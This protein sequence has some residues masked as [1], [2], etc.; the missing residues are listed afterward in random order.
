MVNRKLENDYFNW[1]YFIMNNDIPD[2]IASFRKLFRH[3]HRVEFTYIIPKD[4]NRARDGLDLRY[5]Y[6]LENHIKDAEDRILGPCSV[7]EMM[8]ALALRCEETIMDNPKYGNRTRQ[9][10]WQMIRTLGLNGMTDVS[11][12]EERV[13]R[14]LHIFLNREYCSDGRGGLF[15]VRYTDCDMRKLE[16]WLQ[17]NNYLKERSE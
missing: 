15:R 17:L 11:Y 1:L 9:W 14:A 3:L 8:I 13:E 2:E 12:D 10:F 5:R 6:G 7:L 16:I 4:Y